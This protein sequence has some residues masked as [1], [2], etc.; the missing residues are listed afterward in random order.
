MGF[1]DRGRAAD[2]APVRAACRL[3][4]LGG[5]VRLRYVGPPERHALSAVSAITVFGTPRC[6]RCP[7]GFGAGAGFGGFGTT[8]L[9]ARGGFSS[10][11][12]A[13]N[14]LASAASTQRQ[15]L[16]SLN[17]LTRRGPDSMSIRPR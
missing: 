3:S 6:G 14:R 9:L 10:L 5:Q 8:G 7:G 1:R 15:R 4:T 16:L 2:A 11:A 17:T 12:S 13:D